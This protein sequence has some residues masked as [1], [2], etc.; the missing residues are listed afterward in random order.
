MDF[1]DYIKTYEDLARQVGG[2]VLAN[3]IA[4]R[5][6]ELINGDLDDEIY[7]FY[8]IQDPSFL[9][10]HTDEIVFYDDALDL[11][12]WGITHFGTAWSGV[13]VPKLH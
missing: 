2:M 12:V 8:I 13:P 10:E 7:Q 3:E 5:P 4:K 6:L 11:Y 9:I 1:N